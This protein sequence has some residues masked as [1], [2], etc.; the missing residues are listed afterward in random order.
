MVP[1]VLRGASRRPGGAGRKRTRRI[2]RMHPAPRKR[3]LYGQESERRDL[4]D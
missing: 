1:N 4:G 2:A 3:A